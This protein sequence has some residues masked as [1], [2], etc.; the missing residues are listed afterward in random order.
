MNFIEYAPLAL[1][2]CKPMDRDLQIKHA[3]I[4]MVTEIGEF[5]DM[6]KRHVIYGK[7]LDAVNAKEEIGDYCWYLNLFC[8]QLYIHPRAVTEFFSTSIEKNGMVDQSLLDV[9][10]ALASLTGTYVIGEEERG[11]S[12]MR[13]VQHTCIL[14][15]ALCLETGNTIGDCLDA[16]INK[17]AVRYDDTYSDYRALHRDLFAEQASLNGAP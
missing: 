9:T 15:L 13:L 6:I 16:N 3:Q 5:A 4:G 8:D 11:I 17:L 2:T 7:P 14:L 12:N 10:L 1:R